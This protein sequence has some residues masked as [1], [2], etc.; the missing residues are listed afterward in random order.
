[1]KIAFIDPANNSPYY[2]FSLMTALENIGFKVS[3]FTSK[4]TLD[5]H[6]NFSKLKMINYFFL[7]LS[8]KISVICPQIS[9]LKLFKMIKGIEFIIDIFRIYVYLINNN[10]K[11]VHIH[12]PLLPP[13]TYYFATFLKRKG[14]K[15]VYTVNNI[16]K[17]DNEIN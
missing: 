5:P 3:F 17:K 13:V 7:R 4:F 9:K 2:N 10:Y 11:I 6:I 14:V 8:T 12:W 1:M 16:C 15:I